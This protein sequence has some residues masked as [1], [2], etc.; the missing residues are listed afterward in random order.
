MTPK[1]FMCGNCGIRIERTDK[2]L[3]IPD[4]WTTVYRRYF[5]YDLCEECTETKEGKEN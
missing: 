4:G 5:S 3:S 2:I 1:Y